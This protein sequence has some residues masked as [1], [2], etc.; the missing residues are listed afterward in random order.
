M[1]TTFLNGLGKNSVLL[2]S[3]AQALMLLHKCCKQEVLLL[4]CESESDYL[5]RELYTY[6][7]YLG[8]SIQSIYLTFQ[9]FWL[10][11]TAFTHL[12]KTTGEHT[13]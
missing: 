3:N 1:A 4:L 10:S 5:L 6:K 11:L 12:S 7:S 9:G 8:F 13:K 2:W